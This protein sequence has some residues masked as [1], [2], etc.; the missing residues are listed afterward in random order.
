[1]EVKEAE[2]THF[3]YP[4]ALYAQKGEC[5]VSTILGSCVSVCLWDPLLKIGG[6][7][8]YMLALWNGE[9]LPSPK[10]GNIAITK[11]IEKMLS[12]GRRKGDLKAMVF[13]GGEVL[14]PREVFLVGRATM[15]H[16]G[17]PV[18]VEELAVETTR[19]WFREN[20]HALDP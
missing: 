11:L 10:Y 12:L 1:M 6:I 3:L 15:S 4:G 14:E 2:K 8:H 13:G 7:N 16:R 5:V 17:K 18:P 9:G 19:Q 20:F